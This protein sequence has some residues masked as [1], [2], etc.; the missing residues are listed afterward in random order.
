MA[1]GIQWQIIQTSTSEQPL[2]TH[3][4]TAGRFGKPDRELTFGDVCIA[5]RVIGPAARELCTQRRRSLKT[6]P[7]I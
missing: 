1:K 7:K 4:I 2:S 6:T 5:H 3:R